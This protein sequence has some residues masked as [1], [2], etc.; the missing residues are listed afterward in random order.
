MK[1]TIFRADEN[2]SIEE[3]EKL[4]I[5]KLGDKYQYKSTRKATSLAGKL[6]KSNSVDG[7]TVIKNAYHRTVVSTETIDDASLDSGK[8]TSIY[9]SEATLAGWLS[10]LHNEAGFIGRIIIRAIY[11]SSD[12]I[13]TEVETTI[14]TNIK[15]E[16]E[17]NEYGLGSF[18]KSRI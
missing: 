11:G 8:R 3:I 15:G 6:V 4:L 18:L 7:I 17:T 10:L 2:P 13:Y 14:K 16:D 12:E 5:E 9:F 1:V